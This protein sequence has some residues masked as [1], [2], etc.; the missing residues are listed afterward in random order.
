MSSIPEQL[1]AAAKAHFETQLQ[2]LNTFAG[3]AFDGVEKVIELNLDTAKSSMQDASAAAGNM[4]S[5][6]DPQAFLSASGSQVQPSVEKTI[7]Y[8]RR[9]AEITESVY[10]DFSRIADEKVAESRKKLEEMIEEAMRNAPPGSENAIAV[11]KSVLSNADS[12][13]DQMMASTRQALETLRTNMDSVGDRFAQAAQD[14]AKGG[15]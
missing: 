5:T 13:Y 10:A 9:L 2:L 15:K 3:K 14:V 6:S 11:M 8:N 7:D 12:T 1:A 4:A